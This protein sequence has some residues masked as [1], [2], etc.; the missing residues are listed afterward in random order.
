MG[1]TS[2][3]TCGARSKSHAAGGLERDTNTGQHHFCR[4]ATRSSGATA[5]R[6]L[7]QEPSSTSGIRSLGAVLVLLRVYN[8][9]LRYH[10]CRFQLA[11]SWRSGRLVS[12]AVTVSSMMY[13][14]RCAISRPAAWCSFQ[15]VVQAAFDRRR[16][17]VSSAFQGLI[18]TNPRF[19]ARSHV[20]DLKCPGRP[21]G[22]SA[23]WT[24]HSAG[25]LERRTNTGQHHGSRFERRFAKQLRTLL[26]ISQTLTGIPGIAGTNHRMW[27]LAY[28]IGTWFQ[29]LLQLGFPAVFVAAVFGLKCLELRRPPSQRAARLVGLWSLLFFLQGG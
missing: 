23:R 24:S 22:P 17:Q 15:L 25:G 29:A 11:H 8:D 27:R 20:V 5:T 4:E 10:S 18:C 7:A 2:G 6:A 28:R 13:R 21:L 9:S 19:G 14:L 1:D 16:R 3:R 12:G 26:T